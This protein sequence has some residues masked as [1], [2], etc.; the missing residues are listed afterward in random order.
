MIVAHSTQKSQLIEKEIIP[1]LSFPK[2]DVLELQFQRVARLQ[3]LRVATKLGN[4]FKHKVKII[5][6]DDQTVKCVNTT[7][8]MSSDN[9]V[10]LKNGTMIP[11]NRILEIRLF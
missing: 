11:V 4:N 5:F 9:F 7:I 8:W 10:S 3:A 1:S 6:I 2:H